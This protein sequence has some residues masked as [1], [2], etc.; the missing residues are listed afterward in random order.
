MVFRGTFLIILIMV[1]FADSFAQDKSNYGNTPDA[2]VPYSRYQQAYKSFFDEPQPYRGSGREKLAPTNL[3]TIKIG[4]LGPMEGS[5]EMELG[6]Q[7]LQGAQLAIRQANEQGGYHGIPYELMLHNDVGLWGAAANTVVEMDEEGVWAILGSIDGTVTHVAL[8]IALKLEIPIVNTGDS[9]PT[10]TETRIPWIIRNISDDRQSSYALANEIYE[11]RAYKHVAVLRTNVRYGR[12]GV[13]EFSDASKRLGHPLLFELQF[14]EGDTDFSKQL[15]RISETPAE[16]IV[17]W[18]NAAEA[19]LIVKQMRAL[20]M[21]QAVFG[22]D[23]LVSDE[24]LDIAGAAAE[25]VISTHPYNPTLNKPELK[26][27]QANYIAAY[28]I[29]SDVFA[30]HA[31]DGM[32]IIIEAIEIVGL[33]RVKIRDVLTDLKTFQGYEG[34]TGEL[35]LDNSWN[36]VGAIWTTE[37]I[38]GKFEYRTPYKKINQ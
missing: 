26:S 19:A 37:V 32:N 15:K 3:E 23:R 17:I 21:D 14:A 1:T 13:K 28:N 6:M 12:V 2:I 24:F 31:Y 27:F 30:A 38:K 36:D 16:A 10:L 18:G 35:I 22:S 7:M 34:V 20:G 25:G 5:S 11:K 8:R 4:F 9:D 33:N 29:D